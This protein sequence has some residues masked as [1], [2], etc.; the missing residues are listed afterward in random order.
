MIVNN[1]DIR[2]ISIYE[3]MGYETPS[4]MLIQASR[5]A[6]ERARADLQSLLER[7]VLERAELAKE[8]EVSAAR[9]ARYDRIINDI[10]GT[11]TGSTARQYCVNFRTR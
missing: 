7:M 3:R 11:L 10:R 9:L 1:K 4:A 5:A 8:P 2:C 6:A